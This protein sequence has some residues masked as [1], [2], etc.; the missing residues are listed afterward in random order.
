MLPDE[1]SNTNEHECLNRP[2][3][4]EATLITP[5]S[6][7][8]GDWMV[9]RETL[10]NLLYWLLPWQP[11]IHLAAQGFQYDLPVFP[12]QTWVCRRSGWQFLG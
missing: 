6:A 5:E 10:L 3:Y 12:V 8:L 11:K 7:L 4:A 2:T 1:I 9:F